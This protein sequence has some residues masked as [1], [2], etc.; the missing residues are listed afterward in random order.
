M[1]RMILVN[2][3]FLVLVKGWGDDPSN[4]TRSDEGLDCGALLA[5]ESEEG[6][7]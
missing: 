1:P 3:S 6:G 5:E 2:E 4:D 7:N